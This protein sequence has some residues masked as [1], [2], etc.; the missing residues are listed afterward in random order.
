MLW[1]S[2][3]QLLREVESRQFWSIAPIDIDLPPIPLKLPS[4]LVAHRICDCR[5]SS[6]PYVPWIF[7]NG[8][9]N[10]TMYRASTVLFCGSSSRGHPFIIYFVGFYSNTQVELVAIHLGYY[11]PDARGEKCVLCSLYRANGGPSTPCQCSEGYLVH[12]AFDYIIFSLGI[13]CVSSSTHITGCPSWFGKGTTTCGS[14]IL[15]P[16]LLDMT[17]PL[18]N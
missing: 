5:P 6:A 18:L 4:T 9:V 1:R 17:R 2:L 7:S 10:S 11:K 15:T 16:P 12:C 8:L 3:R 14:S 13:V